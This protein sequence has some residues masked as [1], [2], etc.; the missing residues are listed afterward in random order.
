MTKKNFLSKFLL[1]AVLVLA[2]AL[3]SIVAQVQTETDAPI[4]RAEENQKNYTITHDCT[5]DKISSPATVK[6]GDATFLIKYEGMFNK[7]YPA[8][9]QGSFRITIHPVP[10]YVINY[11]IFTSSIDNPFD[12]SELKFPGLE[13][14][15]ENGNLKVTGMQPGQTY[16][17]YSDGSAK[18]LLTSITIDYTEHEHPGVYAPGSDETHHFDHCVCL[19]R[20]YE[21]EHTFDEGEITL[22][23]TYQRKG[24][25]KYTCTECGYEKEEQVAPNFADTEVSLDKELIYNGSIQFASYT[26]KYKGD[27]VG[28]SNYKVVSG[29][30]RGKEPGD[31]TFTIGP[32]DGSIFEGTKEFTFTIEKG[33]YDMSA[34]VFEDM[35]VDYNGSAQSIL[36]TN[37]PTGVTATY[38]GN[39]QTDAGKYTI[40]AKFTSEAADAQ[41]YNPI[42]DMTAK[43]IINKISVA[44]PTADSTVFTYNG[45]EQTYALA[46]SAL[47]NISDNTA[48]NA[49][50][51][52]A[53]VALSDKNN[54]Q[55]ENGNSNDL[56]YSFT[57]NK[58]TL[59]I[60][61][62]SKEVTYG[63]AVPAYT[64]TYAG[65]VNGETETVLDG[66]L[67]FHCDY[68]QYS[69][70]GNYSIVASGITSN[71]YDISY[72]D[73]NVIVTAKELALS[74]ENTELIYNGQ[75]QQP[76][77]ILAGLLNG[78]S[79][80]VTIITGSE[81]YV[82]AYTATAT[83]L[84]N[85]NYKLPAN[86]TTSF[87]IA[88]AQANI[89]VDTTDINVIYGDTITIPEATTNFGEVVVGKTEMINVG[90]YIVTYS[91]AGTDNYDADSKEVKVIISAKAVAE[92]TVNGTYTYT[93]AEQTV[94]LNGLEAFMTVANN[95]G[96]IVGNYEA[97]I[98]LDS[99]Y[100]WANGSD[101][102]VQWSIAKAQANITVDTTD[103]NVIYGDTIT[104]PEATTNFGE[105]VVG[106]TE[107]INVGEYIVTYSVAGTDNYDA[108]SKEVKVII[109]AKAVAE[110]T[111]NGTYT[112]TG[113]EQTV[114]LNGLEAFMTVANNKGT[115]VGNYEA[116]ITLDSNYK[117]A[118][119][120]DGKVQWSIAKATYDMSG[121]SIAN[122]TV[123]YDGNAYSIT[124]DGT[125]PAG[126]SVSYTN[127]GKT[128]AGVYT[129]T[130]SFVGDANNYN[131]IANKTAILTINKATYDMSAV[132]FEDSSVIYDGS[133]FSLAI[134][135][136]L[137][138]GVTVS[139]ENNAQ[140][141][142]GE[143]TITASFAGDA[144]NYNA[145]ADMTATLTINKATYNMSAVVFEDSTVIYNGS[146][147]SLAIE[148]ALPTGVTVSYENNAQT[149]VGEYTITASFA[150]DATNYN[151]IADMTA[152]LT[153]N[154]A[155]YDMSGVSI[156]DKTVT[157]NGES[158][159]IVITG[160]LP[161]GVSVSYTNNNKTNAG[162]YTITASFT[163]DAN[164]Y[165]A[166]AN[167]TATL[168][169]KSVVVENDVK[170]EETG[171]PVA[172]VEN[173]KGFDPDT[174]LE[175]SPFE[176]GNVNEN[177]NVSKK[178]EI[179]GS[180]EL[181]LQQN[182][183]SVQPD[184]DVVV[185]LLVPV[186][187]G[188]R[189]FRIAH[190]QDG[191]E[192]GNMPYEI[193]DGYAVIQTSKLGEFVFIAE[194]EGLGA[195]AIV[196]I[197]L[198]SFFFLLIVLFIVLYVL[199]K[200]YNVNA[201]SF[202]VPAYREINNLLFK[203]KFNDI[204]LK[205]QMPQ[206]P[207]ITES[208]E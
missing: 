126:V 140:T 109:S 76:I 47:Y 190:V 115:I 160:T 158:H 137:P 50:N 129:I 120:S 49:G 75:D 59:A 150:G 176:E 30:A 205:A 23:P 117:W 185:K 8:Y 65:F 87:S 141:V 145:I 95:K 159:S 156:A 125:L 24:K 196:G 39:A 11:V 118:N 191:V 31:Y 86:A 134:E 135:G 15:Y 193:V 116:I 73:A 93:G 164:N 153:I 188:G 41:Y 101:G 27:K 90:E 184:G 79:C 26:V 180:Y 10:G 69:D 171:K 1:F 40:T 19:W 33:N 5:N 108:D 2:I 98:T 199:W 166:I 149:V 187:L 162:V 131:A 155:T 80:E 174:Q 61:A 177:V 195:G 192:L 91:V 143:Y 42:A 163:G 6:V 202:L 133:A 67:A 32:K 17:L 122:K 154:K 96:T 138:T 151:A 121:I 25:V 146:A 3:C 179:I 172:K 136:T 102:K 123:T 51:Y 85:A 57:I 206:Q 183:S 110:P 71:N 181:D 147:Y 186:S 198:G 112:Y 207:E 94:A 53:K 111:V 157:Y 142:V 165:N 208:I 124:I 130:A 197:V 97:I 70:V 34:V 104:I 28:M 20:V 203:T 55:W 35:T 21:E 100:K 4:A 7:G 128:N 127:N 194:K 119:G 68:V 43:L 200:K 148:G 152:T 74:W 12:T 161:A 13:A 113:A 45:E 169:I 84:S 89:I 37:L 36:A 44:T 48:I 173:D 46:T 182:G 201:L 63:D 60:T 58:A 114:A 82:G 29:V 92:P 83:A 168:T 78:D 9:G 38:E 175:V 56:E 144:T 54:Y 178:E 62:E 77:P 132:V 204:E 22:E 167:M 170:D 52:T 66:E 107:M 64:A 16:E 18:G 139:Y 106:K 81:K 105:V 72:V 88:K 103:I 14:T 189:D 99:N